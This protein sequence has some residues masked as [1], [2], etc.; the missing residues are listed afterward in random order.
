MAFKKKKDI[1]IA[2]AAFFMV[3]SVSL[4]FFV[5]S[6]IVSITDQ[7][8]CWD[9]DR[10]N[11]MGGAEYDLMDVLHE[12]DM[13]F[14]YQCNTELGMAVHV[15]INA[16]DGTVYGMYSK[17]ETWDCPPCMPDPPVFLMTVGGISGI[18]L[19]TSGEW[20]LD[21]EFYHNGNWGDLAYSGTLSF[22]VIYPADGLVLRPNGFGY[23]ETIRFSQ[24]DPGLHWMCVDD[25]EPDYGDTAVHDGA[26]YDAMDLYLVEDAAE[27]GDITSVTVFS[28]LTAPSI[29]QSIYAQIVMATH[30]SVYGGVSFA[31]AMD[32]WGLYYKQWSSNPYTGTAWSWDELND[33]QIGMRLHGTSS[34]YHITCTQVYVVVEYEP[35]APPDI[36]ITYNM[37]ILTI[38]SSC[39]VAIDGVGI[40][41]SDVSGVAVFDDVPSGT[42]QVTISKIGYPMQ[43]KTI[44]VNQDGGGLVDL[45]DAPLPTETIV[46]A[47]LLVA[48]VANLVVLIYL[49]RKK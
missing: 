22:Y 49:K 33:I 8:I 2:L 47:L 16:P 25:V 31:P 43:I 44:N 26:N 3:I 36:A 27:S 42:Y 30:N 5:S 9:N 15:W 46:I 28:V 35:P 10:G 19:Y 1:K 24:C 39:K 20:T 11:R 34:H 12:L 37:N 45:T 6:G 23:Q 14:I 40:K 4:R 13:N 7:V 32:V 18:T 38:P 21:Y 48:V 17:M 29:G 41:T